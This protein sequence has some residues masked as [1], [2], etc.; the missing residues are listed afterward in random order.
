ML[1]AEPSAD[2]T[3]PRFYDE[4]RGD[5]VA[6]PLVLTPTLYRREQRLRIRC[7][8]RAPKKSRSGLGATR[9]R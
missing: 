1:T 5:G 7:D 6:A 2:H 8:V 9:P 4:I 3:V